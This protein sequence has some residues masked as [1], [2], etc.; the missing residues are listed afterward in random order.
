MLDGGYGDLQILDSSKFRTLY[1]AKVYEVKS[2]NMNSNQ[3]LQFDTLFII[4]SKG[5]YPSS[6]M[7]LNDADIEFKEND[8]EMDLQLYQDEGEDKHDIF[9]DNIGIGN[10]GNRTELRTLV[11]IVW[12]ID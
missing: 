4:P 9:I 3:Y 5:Q 1:I 7:H 11:L 2:E 8:E 10:E 6:D 12:V